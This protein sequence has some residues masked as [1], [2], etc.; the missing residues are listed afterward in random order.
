MASPDDTQNAR[1]VGGITRTVNAALA[2]HQAGRLGRAETLYRKALAKNPEH[3]HALHL[4][5]VIAYQRGRIEA[6]IG[7]IERALKE[8][9]DLPEA[10]LDFGNSLCAAGRFADAANSYRRAITLKS[11]YGMAYSNLARALNEQGLF[12]AGLESSRRA[13]ELIPDLLGGQLNYAA[14]LMGLERFAEA[15]AP[16]RR[17][18]ELQPDSAKLHS[19]LGGVL[20]ELARF[21]E[22]LASYRRALK[23]APNEAAVHNNLGRC[24]QAQK[25]FDEAATSY[26]R[27]LALKPDLAEAHN[28]LGTVLQCLGETEAAVASCERAL[29]LQPRNAVIHNNLGCALRVQNRRDDA[30]ASYRRAVALMPDYAQ[31]HCNLGMV[32]NDQGKLDE[33]IACFERAVAIEPDNTGALAAWFRGRQNICDWSCY[34]HDGV[35]VR[36]AV[37]SR[38]SLGGLLTLLALSSTPKQQFGCACRTAAKIIVPETRMQPHTRPRSGERIRVGYV[39]ADFHQHP[40]SSLIAELIERHDRRRFDVFGYSCGS[41]DRDATRVRLTGAFDRFVEIDK[42]TYRQAAALIHRDTVDVLIDLTGYTREGKPA[43]L[44]YR[45]APIQVNYLGYPG[46][47]GADFVDYII[48]DRFLVPSDQ[49]PFYTE[50][51]VHLP[52]CF[53]PSDTKREITEPTPSRAACGLPEEGFVFCCFNNSYKITPTLF[54]IWMRLL[55]ALPRSVLWLVEANPLVKENLRH[56]ATIRGVSAE[57]LVFAPRMAMADYLARLKLADLFLDTL[58]YNAGATANDALW[59][60]LPLLTCA[61]KTYVGRMAGALLTAIGLPELI[62]TSL[63]E[64]EALA[65]RLATEPSGLAGMRQRLARN[66]STMPLFDIAR[67][68][69]DLEAAYSKMWEIWRSGRPPVAFSVSPSLAEEG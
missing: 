7:L 28:N 39:S 36:N 9:G 60:G 58:P 4:L 5:G 14:S 44:A 2:H 57:R 19:D 48:V 35:R 17:A 54:D 51:L 45:P 40:V 27:A 8:L 42:T 65:L 21:G 23:L 61:G 63:A 64:Y 46:T 55:K 29:K 1:R 67:F 25:R 10:H 37:V 30:V 13:I 66:R 38:P 16:L 31:A 26:H 3:A 22:A 34:S 12:A 52:N 41:D 18:L 47:M 33:A 24:L 11:D 56:E 32:L 49:Q 59:A 15:E 6:A 50:R 68:T 62:T 20:T 43:I 69:R 53:Q